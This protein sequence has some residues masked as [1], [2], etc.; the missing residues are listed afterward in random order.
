LKHIPL[1]TCIQTRE[2][3]PKNEL[4]RLAIDPENGKLVLDSS[5]KIRSRGAN[6]SKDIEVFDQAIKSG[7]I[8][9]ALKS[10]FTTEVYDEVRESMR[11]A[12]KREEMSDDSGK[13]VFRTKKD[14]IKLS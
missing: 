9:R 14:D 6:I 5:G 8:A 10:S 12:L 11:S 2:K 7:A 1:R 4:F 3:K 13:V